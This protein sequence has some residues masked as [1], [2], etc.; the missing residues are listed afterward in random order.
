MQIWLI[1]LIKKNMRR[2][3]VHLKHRIFLFK[4]SVI[5]PCRNNGYMTHPENILAYVY[6]ILINLWKS[7]LAE[8]AVINVCCGQREQHRFC[9]KLLSHYMRHLLD[10]AINLFLRISQ[11]QDRVHSCKHRYGAFRLFLES[12][13]HRWAL[14]AEKDKNLDVSLVLLCYN[15]WI[16][17]ALQP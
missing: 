11:K 5:D 17:S 16:T 12:L 10:L 13:S 9:W 8:I 15:D 1:F 3:F 4:S 14:W 2:Q 6:N 7:K